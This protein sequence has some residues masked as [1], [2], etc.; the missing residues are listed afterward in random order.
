MKPKHFL[1]AAAALWAL[2]VLGAAMMPGASLARYA[3][4][5]D[6]SDTLRVA[7]WDPFDRISE[8]ELA[9]D[10]ADS[11]ASVLV[12]HE[13]GAATCLS[14]HLDPPGQALPTITLRNEGEVTARYV[15]DISVDEVSAKYYADKAS[16]LGDVV[17]AFKSANFAGASYSAANGIVIPYGK[18]AVLSVSIPAVTFKGLHIEAIAVQVN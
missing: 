13:D 11:Y 15:L 16:F 10:T 14:T 3:A 1:R 18:Q 2:T 12:I 5:A 8:E 17:V 7:S 6:G 9:E 4:R